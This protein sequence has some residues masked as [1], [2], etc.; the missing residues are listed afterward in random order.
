MDSVTVVSVSVATSS[1]RFAISENLVF[2]CYLFNR[3]ADRIYSLSWILFEILDSIPFH[4]GRYVPKEITVA[5]NSKH[6]RAGNSP[7]DVHDTHSVLFS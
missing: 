2:D 6:D 5:E 3:N 1:C 7:A 4:K